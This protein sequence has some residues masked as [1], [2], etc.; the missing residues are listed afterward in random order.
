[1]EGKQETIKDVF[2]LAIKKLETNLVLEHIKAAALVHMELT[3]IEGFDKDV[4][5]ALGMYQT[6]LQH[7][8]QAARFVG[9]IEKMKGMILARQERAIIKELINRSEKKE[10]GNGDEYIKKILFLIRKAL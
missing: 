7:K 1:M 10:L 4:I 8:H 5:N 6:Y 2:E 9:I 3:M